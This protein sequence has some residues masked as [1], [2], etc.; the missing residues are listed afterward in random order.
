MLVSHL[1]K[2]ASVG[3]PHF[4]AGQ[5]DAALAHIKEHLSW[6]LQRGCD[7]CACC[8]LWANAGR[9]HAVSHV[10]RLV[11]RVS[12]ADHQKM[13]SKKANLPPATQRLNIITRPAP[14]RDAGERV[15]VAANQML[16]EREEVRSNR[17]TSRQDHAS[18][19]ETLRSAVGKAQDLQFIRSYN[20]FC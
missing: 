19:V 4:D 6:R 2:T 9:A 7:T 14:W 18:L 1:Q 3:A 17:S 10:Q 8:G 13:A 16:E 12:S 15:P 11:V 5:E 20:K